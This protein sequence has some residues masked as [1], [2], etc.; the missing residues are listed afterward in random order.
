M[1]TATQPRPKNRIPP[2]Q[3]RQPAEARGRLPDGDQTQRWASLLGGGAL[4]LYGLTKGTLGGFGL[5]A[6]GGGLAYYGAKPDSDGHSILGFKETKTGGLHVHETTAI[7][8]T[9]DELYRFWRNF[10]NFPQFMRYVK[11]VQ[12]TGGNRSHWTACG[13][14]DVRVEWDAETTED[15][16]GQMIAWRSLPGSAVETEGSVRF[17]PAPGNRGTLVNVDMRYNPPAGKAGAALAWMFGRS[18]EQE[19]REDVRRFKRFI[20]TGEIPTTK[21]QPTGRGGREAWEQTGSMV[22][23][24]RMTWGLGWFSIGLGMAELLAPK[25]V[26][27]LIGVRH[28]HSALLRMLGLREIASGVG[29]LSQPRPAGWLWG[30]VAGDAMDLSLLGQALASPH[31]ERGKT[32]AATAA[33]LGITVLDVFSSLQS[34]TSPDAGL[35]CGRDGA[36]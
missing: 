23:E 36:F 24:D 27:D 11:S 4:A 21:G 13:P 19:V 25:T 22:I 30:R 1:A 29:L 35:G 6:L 33:V 5:A 15:R 9:P 17:T 32:L 18:A 10:E 14:M 31:A 2:F 26:A 3:Q 8:S 28:H 7:L 16:P 34:S 12:I 20:E